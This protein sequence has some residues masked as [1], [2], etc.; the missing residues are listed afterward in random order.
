MSLVGE[1]L[2]VN[3]YW[4][5]GGWC[6]IKKGIDGQWRRDVECSIFF[7]GCVDWQERDLEAD[8]IESRDW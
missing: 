3:C 6:S 2:C 7:H 5:E 1:H 8:R 4:N